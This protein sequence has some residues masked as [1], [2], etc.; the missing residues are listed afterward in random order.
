LRFEVWVGAATA[1]RE[2]EIIRACQPKLNRKGGNP[3]VVVNPLL[4]ESELAIPF[5][6]TCPPE[7]R[8]RVLGK[9][10]EVLV[11]ATGY[12]PWP[13]EAQTWSKGS[14]IGTGRRHGQRWRY[15][16]YAGFQDN[17]SAEVGF[18]GY[19]GKAMWFGSV[20]QGE[21]PVRSPAALRALL[22]R[23]LTRW[24]GGEDAPARNI[25]QH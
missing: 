25:E 22:E 20:P 8:L 16:L 15:R 12:T 4:E 18:W 3:K 21:E 2:E 19:D 7:E 5:D 11:Q 10:V 9:L 14:W 23:Y 1:A 6:R 17:D 13:A 24:F